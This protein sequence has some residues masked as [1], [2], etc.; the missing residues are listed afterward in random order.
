MTVF[1]T[2]RALFIISVSFRSMRTIRLSG[3]FDGKIT[4]GVLIVNPPW[5]KKKKMSLD[6]NLWQD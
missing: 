6:V 3:S 2:L 1:F 4:V 5:P